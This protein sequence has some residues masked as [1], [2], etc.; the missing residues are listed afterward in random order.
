MFTT[1]VSTTV[2]TNLDFAYSTTESI[3]ASA[4]LAINETIPTGS[5]D[6]PV[7]FSFSTGSGVFLAMA[8]NIELYPL[9]VKTNSK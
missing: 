9:L 7:N 6:T 3:S 8:T 5:V 2:S 1:T 4:K